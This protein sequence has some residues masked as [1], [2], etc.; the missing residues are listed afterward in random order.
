MHHFRMKA[1]PRAV[2][3]AIT[4]VRRRIAIATAVAL[5]T[6]VAVVPAA[7]SAAK[8]PEQF[9]NRITDSFSDVVC[10]VAVDVQLVG[11]D[12]FTI[13]A[14]DSVKGT[15][16]FR[17]TLT[18]PQNGTSVVVSSAGQFAAMAPIINEAAGTITFQPTFKGLPGKIQT[19]GGAVL[20]RDAGII[21][22]ADTFNLETG[23]LVSH[24]TIVQRGPHPEA[25]SDFTRSCGVIAA[26]LS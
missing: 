15:G 23:E 20:L 2:G 19:A 14:D 17:A 10:G 12:N 5:V 4:S 16:S 13:Y 22:F 24:E 7:A 3:G 18:N 9:H 8:P 21:T 6:A 25:D 11:T 1:G 26:A